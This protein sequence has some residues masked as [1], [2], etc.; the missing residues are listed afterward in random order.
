MAM[1]EKANLYLKY[2]LSLSPILLY[3]LIL[4]LSF[5]LLLFLSALLIKRETTSIP[6]L[7]H[8]FGIRTSKDFL[9]LILIL[10]S[11]VFV[12]MVLIFS[13]GFLPTSPPLPA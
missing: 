1:E 8:L 7:S 4:F 11:A 10:I 5:L 3:P 2:I 13:L 12:L 9:F 6:T